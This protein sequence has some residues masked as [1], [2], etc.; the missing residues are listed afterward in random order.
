MIIAMLLIVAGF[1]VMFSSERMRT[2]AP[3]GAS[4]KAPTAVFVVGAVIMTSGLLVAFITAYSSREKE[5]Q[6]KA[7]TS[8]TAIEVCQMDFFEKNNFYT[9]DKN[10]LSEFCPSAKEY[11]TSN[12]YE[13]KIS[14]SANKQ[15]AVIEATASG[16]PFVKT[17]KSQLGKDTELIAF[18]E[19][20]IKTEETSKEKTKNQTASSGRLEFSVLP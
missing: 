7:T 6:I 12:D 1:V 8:L 16:G 18:S 3:A 15:A 4:S 20:A 17:E 13:V 11:L 14:L 2:A 19:E 5:I 9:D 10:R